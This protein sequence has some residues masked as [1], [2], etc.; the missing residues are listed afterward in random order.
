MHLCST[1]IFSYIMFVC[2]YV[3]MYS[4]FVCVY[5]LYVCACR[6]LFPIMHFLDLMYMYVCMYVCVYVCKYVCMYAAVVKV[7]VVPRGVVGGRATIGIGINKNV[8]KVNNLKATNPLEVSITH[9]YIQTY[10]VCT[11]ACMYV[12]VC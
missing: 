2:M 1:N 6:F 11:C 9:T 10:I 12:H 3:C 8:A 7:S 5:V 4:W